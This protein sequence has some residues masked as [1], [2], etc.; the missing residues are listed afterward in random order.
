M[1]AKINKICYRKSVTPSSTGVV[2][3]KISLPNSIVNLDLN[4]TYS[5]PLFATGTYSDNSTSLVPLIWDKSISTSVA[6]TSYYTATYFEKTVP[7]RC[8]L[9]I[10]ITDTSSMVSNI[11][12]IGINLGG[13]PDYYGTMVFADMMKMARPSWVAT[14][15]DIWGVEEMDTDPN[16]NPNG[17]CMKVIWEASKFCNGIYK[18]I[19][20]GSAETIGFINISGAI[21]NK[22]Y[23]ILTNKTTANL[24][25]FN[26]GTCTG[27]IYFIGTKKTP[28]SSTNTGLSNVKL[29]RQG[30][31]ESDLFTNE[32][33]NV[34]KKFNVIR[35]MDWSSCN[36]NNIVNW[37]DRTLPEMADQYRTFKNSIDSSGNSRLGVCYE[38]MIA[39]CNETNCDMYITL[40]VN[41]NDDYVREFCNL[42]KNGRTDI[43][44]KIWEGL[45]S[46]LNVYVEYGNEIWNAGT[47]GFYCY[48]W[49]KTKS[50]IARNTAGHI[51]ISDGDSNEYSCLFKYV[52]L[53]ICEI[54]NIFRSEFGDSAMHTKIRPLLEGQLGND[55]WLKSGLEF[56]DKYMP[57]PVPYYLYGGGASAYYGS[58]VDKDKGGRYVVD[59]HFDYGNYPSKWFDTYTKKD[60]TLVKSYGIKKVAYEGGPSLDYGV[61]NGIY[62]DD[63]SREINANPKMQDF[64]VKSHNS[65]Q[66]NGGDL[67]C[68]FNFSSV[69]AWEF[70][71][72]KVE[73]ATYENKVPLDTPKL[74]GVTQLRD[75]NIRDK[76]YS[77]LN[78]VGT[79]T[80]LRD[81]VMGNDVNMEG[82]YV[83]DG[84]FRLGGT[85]DIPRTS[86]YRL[87]CCATVYGDSNDIVAQGKTGTKIYSDGIL[88]GSVDVVIGNG[89]AGMKR[90][91]QSS[92]YIDVI[93]QKGKRFI[94][95]VNENRPAFYSIRVEEI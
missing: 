85:F 46:N 10:I 36:G 43:N 82:L 86:T 33:L 90:A 26:E 42:L 52:A 56:I 11:P 57:N 38:Y 63:M 8:V 22:E 83:L 41:I 80:R 67:L 27:G 92:T 6:G 79:D 74:K 75:S 32:F 24:T 84:E 58:D 47:G 13:I 31:I 55:Y 78:A 51:I 50:D 69:P 16:G 39:L 61:S 30:Y 20:E 40:P 71:S 9:T 45:N 19:F 81:Y 29:M 93:L 34:V 23:N 76:Y 94:K 66:D 88:L 14:G 73:S 37:I 5:L 44:G 18:L 70:T 28:T 77:E 64:V 72:Q 35:F 3:I 17:D 48:G 4:E 7:F 12:H 53:R 21:S 60:N 89:N 1:P 68:Y 49:V 59:H 2:L 15:G 87:S 95:F 91:S 25:I 62:T 54:S 65:F